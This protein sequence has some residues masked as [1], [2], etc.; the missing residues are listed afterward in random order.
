LS[1]ALRQVATCQ[2]CGCSPCANES[3]CKV[4]IEQDRIAASHRKPINLPP[5]WE[6]MSVGGLWERLNDPRRHPLPKSIVEAFKH[7]IKQGD[8][9]R[10]KAWL[11]RRAPAERRALRELIEK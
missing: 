1:G 8:P 3:F 4:C 5:G 11:A 6:Q 9:E 7:L 10:L 2:V